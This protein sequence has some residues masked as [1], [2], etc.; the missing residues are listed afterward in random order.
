MSE[1]EPEDA[2]AS[3]EPTE[4]STARPETSTEP[5]KPTEQR[6]RWL[7]PDTRSRRLIV[8]LGIW[9]VCLVVFGLVCGDRLLQHTKY[10]HFAF[11]A[12]A[13]LHGRHDLGGPPPAH[14]EGNDWAL[15]QGKWYV[16]F[17]PF[18]AMLMLPIVAIARDP[19]NF[20]DAQFIVWLAGIGPAGLFLVLEKLRR[21]HRSH[22]SEFEN[23]ALALLFAFGTVY[24]FTAVQGTVW[25]AAH[26]VGVGLMALF[27]LTS[28][29]AERPVLAGLLLGCMFL[30]RVTTVLTAALFAFEA[31]R[32]SYIHVKDGSVRELPQGGTL[33]DR[34]D[35]VLR[36]LD[37]RKLAGI[38]AKFSVPVV[39]ALAFASWYN[40]VRFG[41]P[42]P[43]AF[44]HEYL[45][46]AWQRR[47]QTWG[48]FSYH[49]LGRNLS[50]MLA[51]L[52]WTP[53]AKTTIAAFGGVP[54]KINGHGLALWF[55]TPLYLWL[56]WP[57]RPLGWLGVG[58]IV[59]AM[60][61]L[62]VNLLY[63]N[64]GWVQFGYRFSNDYAIL[65]FVLI[66][67]GGRKFGRMFWLAGVWAL[68]WNLFGAMT[69]ERQLSY[70]AFDSEHVY[71]PD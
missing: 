65:L 36:G 6:T 43:S 53:P 1:R 61:P 7:S 71:Q 62:V 37:Y 2:H 64:S 4:P 47:I 12:D 17:P 3:T 50:A 45:Q 22:R 40:W 8:A 67:V 59:A 35:L 33:L 70:Y 11:L 19:D 38:V 23:V 39:A 54:F 14:A 51:G 60:G 20:R 69:F 48:L 63:Q 41:N 32:V 5:A 9:A 68:A 49:Y 42:S 24:F 29:D 31:I 30:T 57:K 10:N 66:A 55:T 27:V 15:F 58:T 26:V 13:W 28:L 16:S 25:F 21:T 56:F 46:V 18:P 44:G 52:P 34:A